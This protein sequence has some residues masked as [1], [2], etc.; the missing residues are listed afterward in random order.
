MPRYSARVAIS[1]PSP[2]TAPHDHGRSGHRIGPTQIGS[3]LDV[4]HLAAAALAIVESVLPLA[5]RP[6]G[7]RI[8]RVVAQ[9]AHV[10]DHHVHTV[11]ISPAQMA[12]RGVLRPFSSQSGDARRD[13]LAALTLLAEAVILEL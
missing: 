13:V 2:L 5:V 8:I 6:D 1:R 7:T 3:H 12:A 9:L 4:A 11:R 10:L